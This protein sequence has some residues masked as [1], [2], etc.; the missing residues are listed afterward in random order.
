MNTGHVE[1]ARAQQD[2]WEAA[3]ARHPQLHGSEPSEAARWAAEAFGAAGIDDVL[4]L[5]AGHGRDALYLA[6]QGFSVHAT[7]FSETALDQLRQHAQRAGLDDRVTAALHDVRDPL[8]PADATVNAVFANL[9]LNMAFSPAELRTLVGEVQRVLRPGGLF[10]YAV[11]S[12]D[13]SCAGSWEAVDDGLSEHDGF[14]GRFF[15]RGLVDEL[16][17]G[18][19][20]V[21]ITP[22]AEPPRRLW[23]V[24]VAKR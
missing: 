15:D 12:A 1:L 11:W 13:D 4:E 7:D 17:T 19:Q 24:A 18:W 22:Y 20:P 16:S 8:P 2:R 21:D 14:V 9:L 5:G 23:R 6:A 3:Y 10:V